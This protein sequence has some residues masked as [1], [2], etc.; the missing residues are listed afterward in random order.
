MSPCPA[1]RRYSATV[2]GAPTKR[3]N[4]IPHP[5][6][7]PRRDARGLG[8]PS[9]GTRAPCVGSQ[10]RPAGPLRAEAAP[11]SRGVP[12]PRPKGGPARHAQGPPRRGEQ[13]DAPR[14]QPSARHPAI[15]SRPGPW[16]CDRH[17]HPSPCYRACRCGRRARA[18]RRRR[19]H[20]DAEPDCRPS[21]APGCRR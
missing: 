19:Q 16:R 5:L 10:G 14:Q 18:T 13:Q 11:V 2:T 12:A 6:G 9:Q 7:S 3:R 15:P 20:R 8:A 4:A 1:P 17:E 21:R